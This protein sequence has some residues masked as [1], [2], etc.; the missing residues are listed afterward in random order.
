MCVFCMGERKRDAQCLPLGPT[1]GISMAEIIARESCDSI[2]RACTEEAS[3]ESF[4]IKS[5]PMRAQ[6]VSDTGL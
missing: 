4:R 5:Q 3:A 1:Y 2:E 6:C